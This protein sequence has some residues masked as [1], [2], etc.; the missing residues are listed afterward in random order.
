[1]KII[2]LK[3]LEDI[4][5]TQKKLQIVQDF[6]K[7]TKCPGIIKIYGS[8][9]E[10]TG[11]EGF[12]YYILMELAQTDWEEEI[13]YR[14]QHNLYYSEDDMNNMI[15]QLVKCYALLQKNNV[16]HRDVKP[17]NILLLNGMYKVCDFGEARTI[18]GKNGYIHQPIRGSELYMSPILF[19]ALNIIL[20]NKIISLI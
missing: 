16:S 18:S 14:S 17:Q 11:L 9:Y 8:L 5:D 20:T 4:E 1:M 10:K 3:Y 7:K 19:D 2:N 13:K 6:L 15:Q 12:K